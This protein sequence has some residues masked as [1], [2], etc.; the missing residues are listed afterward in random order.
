M[1]LQALA[2]D[3]QTG[4][5]VLFH[6]TE[7]TDR[8][9]EE[10][11]ESDFSHM[12]MAYR[13]AGGE[14]QL[15]QSWEPTGGVGLAPFVEFVSSKTAGPD[16]YIRRLEVER[17]PEMLDAVEAFQRT[18][19]GRRFPKVKQFVLNYVEGQ[20]GRD[21]GDETFF[22]SQLVAATYMQMGI[23]SDKHPPNYY[24]PERYSTKYK[25]LKLIDGA[26]LGEQI[27]LDL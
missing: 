21:S 25:K 5:I 26:S 9:I 18:V 8:L 12:G 1:K 7:W 3:L 16:C 4:D 20:L 17:T 24:S 11:T 15:W 27:K 19:T 23:Q 2:P 10:V 14:L 22:C 6:G 13:A